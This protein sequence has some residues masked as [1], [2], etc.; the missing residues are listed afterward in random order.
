MQVDEIV[1][2]PLG[3]LGAKAAILGVTNIDGSRLQGWF[4]VMC[5]IAGFFRGKTTTEGPIIFGI[6][7]NMSATQL[8]AL[9]ATDP[10][11]STSDTN[12]I[13]AF[14]YRFISII[15]LDSTEGDLLARGQSTEIQGT[16]RFESFKV[17][18]AIPEGNNFSIFAYNLGSGALTTGTVFEITLQNFGSWLRD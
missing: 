1:S 14:W 9:I 15:G 4:Q 10:Q 16:S 12:L 11:G 3:T 17:R 6:C 13:K 18:W 5:N 7:A 2:L 8:A